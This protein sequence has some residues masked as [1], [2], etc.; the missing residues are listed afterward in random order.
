MEIRVRVTGGAASALA[1]VLDEVAAERGWD[2]SVE[3]GP[4]GD[5][6]LVRLPDDRTL[7][8][9]TTVVQTWEAMQGRLARVILH[10]PDGTVLHDGTLVEAESSGTYFGDTVHMNGGSGNTGI[11]K[12]HTDTPYGTPPG[13]VLDPGD[14]WPEE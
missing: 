13:P 4:V 2:W 9:L 12:R 14:D 10:G 8:V 1:Q 6:L 11:D 7:S 5:E 3:P